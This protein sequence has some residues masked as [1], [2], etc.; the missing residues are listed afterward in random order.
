MKSNL[1]KKFKDAFEK[2]EL[3]Y[4]PQA[5]EALNGKLDALQATPKSPTGMN[6]FKWFGG[7]A[8][9][10]IATSAFIYTIATA[11]KDVNDNTAH[12][13]TKQTESISTTNQKETNATAT[14]DNKHNDSNESSISN[15]SSTSHSTPES[16][17]AN[18]AI[19]TPATNPTQNNTVNNT[20]QKEAT[21]SQT[22]KQGAVTKPT[23]APSE[24]IGSNENNTTF[25]NLLLDLK[26]MCEGDATKVKNKNATALTII[27]PSGKELVVL[28]H[29]TIEFKPTETGVYT[30]ASKNE[31]RTIK[32]K[33]A[34]KLDFN[35]NE[36]LKYENG[37]PSIPCETYSEASN[38]VWNF[39]GCSTKQY[40]EKAA[41]HFYKRGEFTI[42]LTA[43]NTD[44]CTGSVT[45]SVTIE[46]NYNLLAPS[47]FM[48][49]SDDI[50]KNRFI[51]IALTLRNTEFKMTIFDPRTGNVVFETNSTEGWD[52]FDRNT[53][54]LVDEN[55]SFA[56][57][58]VLGN[59][60][61]GEQKEYSGIVVRM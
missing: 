25:I 47:G 48:P 12:S 9:A 19:T 17:V 3:P 30:I 1:D 20:T 41:A 23:E 46:E 34:P 52:G 33:E 4:N 39:Q 36:E 49:K 44:G 8:V 37:I 53:R 45:K 50:R 2:Y 7:A 14:V 54:Q 43:K 16:A 32:V 26:D 51:P 6:R 15:E 61:V 13:T 28:A 10:I 21:A 29:Q 55:K 18:S 57:K 42:T 56:W 58:V 5:W 59:P 27:A 31:A 11:D 35:I 22:T 60:E 24:T 40:G 38:F